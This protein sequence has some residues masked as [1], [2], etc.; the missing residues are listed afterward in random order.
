MRK[1]IGLCCLPIFLSVSGLAQTDSLRIPSMEAVYRRNY[2]LEAENPVAL[3]F[4]GFRSFSVAEAGYSRTAGDL[5][6]VTDPLSVNAYSVF[7]ESFQTLGVVSLYGKLGYAQVQKQEMRWNGMTRPHWQAV[8]LC[9]SVAGNQTFEQYRL[10]GA[11]SLPVHPRWWVGASFDYEVQLTAKN[12]DPRNKNQWMEWQLTPGVAYQYGKLKIGASVLYVNSKEEVDYRHVGTHASYPVFAAYPLCF[13]KTIPRG[14]SSTWYYAGQEI[15]GAL[16]L[17]FRTG[18]RQLFQQVRAGSVRQSIESNRILN[19]REGETDIWHVAYTAKQ[20]WQLRQTEH[21]ITLR[22]SFEQVRNFDNLQS[23]DAA[24]TWQPH[25]RVDRSKRHVADCDL[26]YGFYR[27]R[28]SWNN[29][30]SIL[31]GITYRKEESALLFYPVEYSQPI[32]RFALH[33][34]ATRQWVLPG[35]QLDI[36]FG[37]QYGDGGGSV[38]NEIRQNGQDSPDIPLWQNRELLQQLFDYETATRWKLSASV[39]YTRF[40]TSAPLAWFIRLSGE[41]EHADKS[42][43]YAD[44]PVI[45]IQV[46]LLF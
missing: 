36:S 16:Q 19:R 6:K 2:W 33:V 27:L 4:N 10:D 1:R 37:G 24:G 22:A 18:N 45:N 32:H 26:T 31:S 20:Q 46:G 15:G 39:G 38:L 7:S 28:D 43:F 42:L 5:R 34:T 35:A 14:E 9:D 40:T 12:I 8:N 21:K 30:F 3:S 17:D 29:R 23:Q 44:K 11:F 25:G 41:Y 13:L